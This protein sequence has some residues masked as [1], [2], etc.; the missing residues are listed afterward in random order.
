MAKIYREQALLLFLI[1]LFIAPGLQA[2]LN[3][4]LNLSN[5]ACGGFATG[6]I[7]A[8]PLNGQQPY[9]YEWSNG[10][11][12]NP[13]E[14]IPAGTYTVTVT[15]FND[16]TG[17]ATGTL[18]EPPELFV[19]IVVTEC[20]LP[21]EMLAAV[22]GGIMPYTYEWSTGE[23]TPSI[24]N[25]STGLYCVTVTDINS[26][27]F[28]TCESIGT[29]LSLTVETDS[30]FCGSGIGG[31]A[32]VDVTGGVWPF[33]YEWNTGQTTDTITDL[34]P[35]I[36]EVTVTADNGCTETEAGE[37]FLG[38]GTY[39]IDFDNNN[40]G[41]SGSNT[42][43]VTAIA[44]GGFS[45]YIYVWSTG[46]TAATV[47]DLPAGT[48]YVTAT[49]DFGC[50]SNDS[51]E[52][53]TAD[54]ISIMAEAQ[55]PSCPGA[56]NGSIQITASNGAPP[57][58]Y[59]WNTGDTTATLTGLSPGIYIV[60]VT[61]TLN[62]LAVDTSVLAAPLLMEL[63]VS[64]TDE[65]ECGAHDGT[66]SVDVLTGG[67]SPLSYLWS[68]GDTTS[69]INGLSSGIYYITVTDANDCSAVDSTE[70]DAPVTLNVSITGTEKVCPGAN[71][72]ELTAEVGNGTAP[73]SFEWSNGATTPTIGNL[74][75]GTYS[76]S[77]TSNEG[78]TG[79][80]SA[81][82]ET[83]PPLTISENVTNV[84]CYGFSNGAIS[85]SIGGG[86][87]PL[88]I[89]WE[90]GSNSTI[91]NNL[92]AG[93][94]SLTVTD[95]I[96]CTLARNISVEQPDELEVE[97]D[98]SGGSCGSNGFVI[99]LANGGTP[100]YSYLWENGQST[101]FL[102]NLPPGN[103]TVTVTDAHNCT[104]AE[105][106]NV[107]PY[108]PINLTVSATDTN[109]NGTGDGTASANPTGGNP[110]FSYLWSNGQTSQTITQLVPGTYSVTVTS[111]TG[112]TAT[113]SA[114]VHF[115]ADLSILIEGAQ[116]ICP[117]TSGTLTA[118]PLGGTPPFNYQWSNGATSPNIGN[119]G[120]GTWSVSVADATGCTGEAS[121]TLA[122]GG[123]FT[124]NNFIEHV[125]CFGENTGRIQLSV[126]NGIPPYQFSWSN[127]ATTANIDQLAAGTY[128]VTVADATACTQT[129]DYFINQPPLLE[130]TT[131][132]TD[133]TCG[134]L[135]SVSSSV[136][137]G[138]APYFYMWSNGQTNPDIILLT[139]GGTY[140][141]TVTDAKG[142]TAVSSATIEVIPSLSC[143]IML[144]QPVSTIF[145]NDGQLTA[146]PV[147][148][149][150]PF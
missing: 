142:C 121:V 27:A 89:L 80:A 62:C 125:D 147:G 149:I 61:D 12:G 29:L 7:E 39:D 144:V 3:I 52:L 72:G 5:P 38:P 137:G 22:T 48:Y 120:P 16:E 96:G 124:V 4:A 76:I 127:G 33:E 78:C 14:N 130:V 97:F 139:A 63:S 8:I 93:N 49:D 28:Q 106:A 87:S 51:T 17:T 104:R 34:P 40:P 32:I 119:L 95:A 118:V 110:P 84:S 54:S 41:C 20:S 15:D 133:G 65:S 31:T 70:V 135:G 91:R 59:L 131:T 81:T 92:S 107:P 46:D 58:S 150:G 56:A 111:A 55:N 25:L 102:N 138:T 1:I 123:N 85:V 128:T 6:S 114:Q 116:Y 23:A 115:G 10:E 109:C 9:T 2:Q 57:Y 134:N 77:V 71:N 73:F 44:S 101:A 83:N 19:E 113:G 105:T 90:N 143:N 74:P 53:I 18:T 99:A 50:V 82:I 136:T 35:G 132:G 42:G 75:A 21:G 67:A 36:Y 13:L 30:A 37:V 141:L 103:Y 117:G 47:N 64:S 24:S 108:P 60:S 145:G 98:S 86:T 66:A 26:C 112:C 68:N 11:T 79:S 122:N 45:P 69:S 126:I 129:L 148:G 43:S 140:T 100:P 94:Y 146:L 88:S